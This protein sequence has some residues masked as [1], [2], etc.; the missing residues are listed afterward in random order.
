M[1]IQETQEETK[2]QQPHISPADTNNVLQ[3][4]RLSMEEI[5]RDAVRRRATYQVQFA[6]FDL[7]T[8]TLPC[9]LTENRM[10]NLLDDT[11]VR[12]VRLELEM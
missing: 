8:W 12:K 10:K 1:K 9:Q 6:H 11:S 7:D 2:A 5:L 4:V 3:I